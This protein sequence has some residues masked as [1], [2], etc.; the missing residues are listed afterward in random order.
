MTLSLLCLVLCFP[1]FPAGDERNPY[2]PSLR[3]LSDAEEDQLDALIDRFI[4]ADL[5][6]LTGEEAKKAVRD[7][8]KLGPDAIPALIRGLNRAARI[9]ASCPASLIARKLGRMLAATQDRELLDFAREN[10]GAGVGRSRHTPVLE[11]LR[12]ACMLRKTA[13]R[14]LPPPAA[15][16]PDSERS[17]RTLT[18]NELSRMAGSERGDKLRAVLTELGTRKG[19]EALNAL[20]SA[21]GSYEKETQQL[22]RTLLDRQ[23][24]KESVSRIKEKMSDDRGEMRLSAI[25]IVNNKAVRADAELIERLADE[26]ETV[27]AAAHQ[28]L[29]RRNRGTDLGPK[30]GASPGEREEAIRRWRQWLE[31]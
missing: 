10:I 21:A 26:D 6:K 25:R 30:P 4:A 17:L 22:A 23:L 24:G 20:A 16:M 29:V 3:L 2:A 27:R 18:V 14:R 11:D 7:F 1:G 8:E 19:D 31:K 13:L 9:E 15:P 12:V 5:G 28:S